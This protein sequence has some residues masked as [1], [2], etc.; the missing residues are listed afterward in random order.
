M[1][2]ILET[3]KEIRLALL[4]D[5]HFHH[6]GRGQVYTRHLKQVAES[7]N[8]AAVKAVLVA[9]DLT[10]HG[11]AGEAAG[12]QELLEAFRVPVLVV[13]GNH[14]VGNKVWPGRRDEAAQVTAA[15][16]AAYEKFWGQCPYARNVAGLRVIGINSQVL[17]SALPQE[18]AQWQFLETE[19]ATPDA[20]PTLVLQHLPPFLESPDEA[21]DPYWNIEPE[22]RK[23]LLA[24]LTRGGVKGLL[25]GHLH[26]PLVREYTG[27]ICITTPPVS[28]GLPDGKQPEGWTLLH[29]WC[30][31]D[32]QPEFV[33]PCPIK[34]RPG[35]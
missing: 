33:Y 31:G 22:P 11:E 2:E 19:L 15:R 28:F 7:V 25:S 24:L 32:V 21:G 35:A 29:V 13:P 30:C 34:D 12:M 1:S 18:E 6:G 8:Q 20:P 14:D 16:V 27:F 26:R 4:G 5:T 17:G 9:G 10:E 3:M 23:R